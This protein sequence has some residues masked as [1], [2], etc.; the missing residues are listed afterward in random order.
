MRKS[1]FILLGNL[2]LGRSYLITT[3]HPAQLIESYKRWAFFLL[4]NVMPYRVK[5]SKNFHAESIST[6]CVWLCSLGVMFWNT[7]A[8]LG[9]KKK[10]SR[11]NDWKIGLSAVQDYSDQQILNLVLIDR[12]TLW[13]DIFRSVVFLPEIVWIGIWVFI[14]PWFHQ[15]G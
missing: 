13:G 11:I 4:S 1:H 7:E 5:E 6:H 3:V 8:R 12:Q 10:F 14:L 15:R 2:N 9:A